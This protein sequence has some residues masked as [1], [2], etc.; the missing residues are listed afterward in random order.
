MRLPCCLITAAT[1]LS[2]HLEDTLTTLSYMDCS[3]PGTL[4]NTE[5]SWGKWH[6]TS[7][8]IHTHACTRTHT[9]A[10]RQTQTQTN[11]DADTQRQTQRQTDNTHTQLL[12]C[13]FICSMVQ[14]DTNKIPRVLHTHTLFFVTLNSGLETNM[15][16]LAVCYPC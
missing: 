8:H 5:A 11:T 7:T 4:N 10:R 9:H 1:K 6:H 13:C 14:Q 16:A 3:Y 12:Q 2:N 15:Y